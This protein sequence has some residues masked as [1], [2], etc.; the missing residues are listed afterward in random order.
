MAPLLSLKCNRARR[1]LRRHDNDDDDD[2]DD[3]PH[4]HARLIGGQ[5]RR[6]SGYRSLKSALIARLES[7][8]VGTTGNK[9]C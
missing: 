5:R 9:F 3:G 8:V 1:G 6:T 7:G 2:D 4:S